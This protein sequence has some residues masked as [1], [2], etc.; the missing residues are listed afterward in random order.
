M[1]PRWGETLPMALGWQLGQ[2][3]GVLISTRSPARFLK[4][5]HVFTSTNPSS[6]P[7]NQVT[8]TRT[9][10]GPPVSSQWF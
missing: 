1:P 5:G 2:E 3:V 10:M 4:W 9:Q 6:R 8:R 7:V